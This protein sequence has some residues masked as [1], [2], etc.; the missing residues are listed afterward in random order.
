MSAPS[1]LAEATSTML[2]VQADPIAFCR[3]IIGVEPWYYQLDILHD[4]A[5]FPQVAAHTGH[6]VG[7]TALGAW[8]LLWFIFTRKDSRVVTSAPTW[9]QVKDLLWAEVHKWHRKMNLEKMG[10]V[11]PYKLL[12]VRLEV[13]REWFAT[14]EATDEEE[15]IEGYHAE[16]ILYII[17][18]AKA[19]SDKILDSMAGGLT[20]AEARMLLLSTPGESQG[21]LYRV[22]V[23]KAEVGRWKIHHV[24]AADVA[25][26]LNGKQVSK[27]WV[28]GR[29][30]TWGESSGI[31]QLRVLGDFVDLTDDRF[32][33]PVLVEKAMKLEIKVGTKAKRVLSVDPARFGAD[34]TVICLREGNRV[35]PLVKI[36]NMDLVQLTEVVYNEVVSFNPD[37]I[38]VDE[39]GLGAGL[40]DNLLRK[41]KARNKLSAYNGAA[42]P[43][44]E[45]SYLNCR[46]ETYW[47]LRSLLHEEEV[48]LP[49]DE[50]LEGQLTG[51]KY[52]YNTY[53]RHTVIKMESKDDM[54]RRGMMSPNEADAIVM[55]FSDELIGQDVPGIG[56]WV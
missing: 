30:A 20:T 7:K 22:C 21:K 31:Y 28:E 40:Y 14:G 32:I 41:K 53:K 45:D 5:T 17:D 46:A 56:V 35:H 26:K 38:I 33:S 25:E 49:Q 4:L 2:R 34:R 48:Q 27:D 24:S 10:W 1:P 55:A 13:S 47:H 36:D 12:D 15:K 44:D 50:L 52:Q 16:S 8:A 54:R 11:F 43:Q 29:K 18:E 23:R 3:E 19:V 39:T 51:I 9:R 42:S 37:E 6:G